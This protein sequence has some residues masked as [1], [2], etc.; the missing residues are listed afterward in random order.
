MT[1]EPRTTALV[2]QPLAV[3]GAVMTAVT[4][5]QAIFGADQALAAGQEECFGVALAGEN[6]CA[7]GPGTFCQGQSLTDYQGNAWTLVAA[8]TCEGIT[9]TDAADGKT[10]NGSLEAIARDLPTKDQFAEAY[11]GNEDVYMEQVKTYKAV[12]GFDPFVTSGS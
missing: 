9:I 6:G 3:A 7:A 5:G 10:R 1:T 2:A 12:E 8:G 4:G 11:P